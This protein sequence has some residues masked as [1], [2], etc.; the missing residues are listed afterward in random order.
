[1]IWKLCF[2][3]NGFDSTFSQVVN[4]RTSY[5]YN[6]IIWGAKFVN[7]TEKDELNRTVTDLSKL[8]DYSLV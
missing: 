3:I 2:I 8:G 4:S 5:K 6:E 1:M 7:L